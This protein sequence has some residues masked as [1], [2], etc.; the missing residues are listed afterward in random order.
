MVV[1]EQIRQMVG[2]TLFVCVFRF[3]VDRERCVYI[4]DALIVRVALI[5]SDLETRWGRSL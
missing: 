3:V 1:S 2:S 4:D 5:M